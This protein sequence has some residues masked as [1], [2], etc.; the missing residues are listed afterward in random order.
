MVGVEATGLTVLPSAMFVPVSADT[1]IVPQTVEPF[2]VMPDALVHAVPSQYCMM[3]LEL[4]DVK[5]MHTWALPVVIPV[6]CTS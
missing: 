3:V 5:L 1:G 2:T 6:T 4:A